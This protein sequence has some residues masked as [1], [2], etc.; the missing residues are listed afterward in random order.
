MTNQ[1][2]ADPAFVGHLAP[3]D[4]DA[5]EADLGTTY[6]LWPDL[7]LAYFNPAWLKFAHGN[8]GEPQIST[9]WPLGRCILDALADPIRQFFLE[10]YQ[11]CL[12]EQRPWV[13]FYECSSAQLYREAQ[14]TAFPVGDGDGLLIVNSIRRELEHSRVAQAAVDETY[15]SKEGIVTQCCHCR[16]V[17]RAGDHLVWDWVPDWV[18]VHPPKTSHGLCAPCLGYYYQGKQQGAGFPEVFATSC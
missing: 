10:N 15:R 8:R 18:E 14:M 13:H 3:F 9:L 5:L 16:R 12:K 7:T 1:L 2:H 4:I 11:R 6:G 17:R